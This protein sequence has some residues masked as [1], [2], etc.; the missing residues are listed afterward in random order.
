VLAGARSTTGS[1]FDGGAL[2]RGGG[3]SRNEDDAIEAT[4]SSHDAGWVYRL[5]RGSMAR[6]PSP[7]S[8]AVPLSVSAVKGPPGNARR[9]RGAGSAN[10][11]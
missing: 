11:G 4:G 8:V 5:G 6:R 7:A 3:L 2:R 10:P 9:G 1:L